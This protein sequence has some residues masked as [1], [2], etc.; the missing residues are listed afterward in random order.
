[1][2][3][4]EEIRIDIDQVDQELT[5]L[6]EKRFDLVKEVATYKQAN[7]QPVLDSSREEAVILK[8]QE[9]LKNPEYKDALAGLY[10]HL[11]DTSKELQK[12]MM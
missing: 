12:K 2:R 6:I 3:D 4:L 10:Q 8:N 5:A 9:R 1:M 11:M 7:K